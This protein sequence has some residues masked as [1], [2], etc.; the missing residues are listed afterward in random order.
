MEKKKKKDFRLWWAG[1]GE[2]RPSR[3]QERTRARRPSTT[4]GL[5]TA[6]AREKRHRGHGV[7]TLGRARGE[8]ALAADGV[9]ANLSTHGGN[10]AAG[11]FN[12]DSPPVTQFLGI[13]KA[14]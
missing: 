14:P 3:V 13:E 8:T 6:R 11:G 4:H 12:G 5:E 2:F 10:L 7:N 1:G 9:G